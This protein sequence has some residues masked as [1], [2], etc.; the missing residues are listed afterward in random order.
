MQ[1]TSSFSSTT[2]GR[3]GLRDLAE[4]RQP[5]ATVEPRWPQ[6]RGL[7]SRMTIVFRNPDGLPLFI[8]IHGRDFS[9]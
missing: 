8:G 5:I 3:S 6:E 7:F 9:L 2:R 1:S 4:V